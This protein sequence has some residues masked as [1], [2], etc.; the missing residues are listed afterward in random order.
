[1][2]LASKSY[3]VRILLGRKAATGRKI[4]GPLSARQT[5]GADA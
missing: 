2:V 4:E 3:D 1:M 5:A